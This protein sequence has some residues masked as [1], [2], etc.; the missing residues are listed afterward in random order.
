MFNVSPQVDVIWQGQI[1]DGGLSQ[2][3]VGDNVS[4]EVLRRDQD[5]DIANF[6]QASAGEFYSASSDGNTIQYMTVGTSKQVLEAKF[7]S[8]TVDVSID[9]LWA[10]RSRTWSK[11]TCST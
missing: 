2:I 1:L 9:G 3:R 8:G 11:A 6:F 7:V 5:H 4:Y 10:R